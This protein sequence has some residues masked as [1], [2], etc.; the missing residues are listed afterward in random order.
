V[1]AFVYRT[2]VS[3]YIVCVHY[4]RLATVYVHITVMS[5]YVHIVAVS[6]YSVH[7]TVVSRA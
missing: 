7:I 1:I 6:S 5:S 4:S 3:S 2:A